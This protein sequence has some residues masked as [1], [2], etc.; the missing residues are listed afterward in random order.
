MPWIIRDDDEDKS[1]TKMMGNPSN[2]AAALIAASFV[3]SALEQKLA[4]LFW[5]DAEIRDQILWADGPL[6]SFA[7]RMK[8]C[9]LMR[10]YGKTAYRELNTI[11]RVRN[12]FAHRTGYVDFTTPAIRDLC[13]NLTLID[14]YHITFDQQ[15]ADGAR[16]VWSNT[17]ATSRLSRS[18]PGSVAGTAATRGQI[19]GP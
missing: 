9:Y 10:L 15:R 19:R 4:D 17:T 3:D 12:E 13:R 14:G 7:A 5:D 2:R 18:L 11:R 8:A 6:G 16:Y 1:F